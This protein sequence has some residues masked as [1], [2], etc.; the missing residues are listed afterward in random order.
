[1]IIGL[2]GDE[3]SGKNTVANYLHDKYNFRTYALSEPIKQM[4]RNIFGWSDEQLYGDEKDKVDIVT[5]IKPREFFKWIGT[6][7]FQY[8]IHS[9]FPEYKVNKRCTWANVMKKYLE[10][11]SNNSHIVVTDIRFK[12]EAEI[13]VDSGGYLVYI[14]NENTNPSDNYEILDLLNKT[15]KKTKDAWV[16]DTIDNNNITLQ[17]LYKNVDV[18]LRNIENYNSSRFNDY[19]D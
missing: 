15:N 4:G 7:I 10:I 13:L 17:E 12:H 19:Y 11:H 16:F 3:R 5:G 8:D 14:D 2:I 6:T 18:T 9:R 1:M